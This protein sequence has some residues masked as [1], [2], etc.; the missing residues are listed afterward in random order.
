MVAINTITT[1]QHSLQL[2]KNRLAVQ[3]CQEEYKAVQANA[4]CSEVGWV[5]RKGAGMLP[6][7][8]S[9]GKG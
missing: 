8:N 3:Q 5:E 9:F 7:Y 4:I 1:A 2:S 6:P